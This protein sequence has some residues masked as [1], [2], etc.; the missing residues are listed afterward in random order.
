MLSFTESID[1]LID[2]VLKN[3]YGPI[4]DEA[5]RR[6][7][8]YF[9]R[10][11]GLHRKGVL[12]VQEKH[13]P[14]PANVP[15]DFELYRLHVHNKVPNLVAELYWSDD[16]STPLGIGYFIPKEV[17]DVTGFFYEPYVD[18]KGEVLGSIVTLE[19]GCLMIGEPSTG[20][21]G[22]VRVTQEELNNFNG[23]RHALFLFPTI[24]HVELVA[25]AVKI[26]HDRKFEDFMD[27]L[28]ERSYTM[29]LGLQ[30]V[31]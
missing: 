8:K 7:I 4:D 28:Y 12:E 25:D 22:F 21:H 29:S 30:F 6:N 26:A 5:S 27:G 19:P 17:P 13:S 2:E 18:E 20:I 23:Y 11:L 15:N 14:S 24:N 31:D 16:K 10:E 3:F 9:I 1:F